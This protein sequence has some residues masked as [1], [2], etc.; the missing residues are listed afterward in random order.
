MRFMVTQVLVKMEVDPFAHARAT[1]LITRC[2]KETLATYTHLGETH[3]ESL[4]ICQQLFV[5][6]HCAGCAAPDSGGI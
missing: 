5:A 3:M 6:P 2:I 1:Y 4:M